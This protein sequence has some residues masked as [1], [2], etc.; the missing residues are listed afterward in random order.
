[1]AGEYA[2]NLGLL[3]HQERARVEQMII[4]ATYQDRLRLWDDLHDS[5]DLVLDSIVEWA[6]HVNVYDI[7]KY[8]VYP[9]ALVGIYLNSPDARS[10]YHWNADVEF[11]KQAGNVYEAMYT[12]FMRPYV[13]LVE[14]LLQRGVY[15]MVYN[16][17]NDLIVET[18]GTFKWAEKVHYTGATK[19]K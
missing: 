8:H 6:G 5:F 11:G 10:L 4:N 1:M 14:D 9:D 12:D 3:D 17:Q 15:V 19:F 13:P 18:P 7:T 2:Y 16:G